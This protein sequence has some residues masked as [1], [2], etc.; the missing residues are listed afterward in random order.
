MRPKARYM[1]RSEA[2]A[3]VQ[4]SNGGS[5]GEGG[6]GIP[7][8]GTGRYRLMIGQTQ[9]HRGHEDRGAGGGVDIHGG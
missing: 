9:G 6:A 1:A 8:L 7:P 3:A 4:G 5:A 2:A